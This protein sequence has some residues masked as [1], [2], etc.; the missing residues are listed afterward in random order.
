MLHI[1][2]TIF[3]QPNEIFTVHLD[4]VLREAGFAFL[5]SLFSIMLPACP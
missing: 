5:Y 1:T 2:E 3:V 4:E